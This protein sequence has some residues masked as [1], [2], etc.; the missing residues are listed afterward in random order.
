MFK[1]PVSRALLIEGSRHFK[2]KLA[3]PGWIMVDISVWSG[4][5]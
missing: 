3:N 4:I 5:S 2:D 1:A